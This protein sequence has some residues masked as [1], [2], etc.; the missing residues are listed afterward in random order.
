MKLIFGTDNDLTENTQVQ[1]IRHCITPVPV[2]INEK[3]LA[4]SFERS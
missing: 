4:L 1:D 3:L 2:Q